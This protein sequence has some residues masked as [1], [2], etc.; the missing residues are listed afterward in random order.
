[1][2]CF[3]R[4]I[5][6]QALA[7]LMLLLSATALQA[8]TFNI[9]T[10][11]AGKTIVITYEVDVN[12]NA[13]PTGTL[14]PAN[15]SNQ[16]NVSGSNF[17]TVQT[18]DPSNPAADPSPTLTPFAGLSVGNLVYNDLNRD[19]DYDAGTDAGINGVL[20]RIY[21]DVNS[22]NVLDAGDGVALG[23]ATSANVSGQDGTYSFEVCP[24]VYIIEVAASNF[25]SGGALFNGGSPYVS[26]P[27]GGATDPDANNTN[28]DDNGDPVA[29]FGVATAAFT[30]AAA[31]SN[32]D[33][34]FKTPTTVTINNVTLAEG[35]GGT[36]TAYNFTVTRNDASEAFNLTV[37]T[38]DGTA[39]SASDYTAISGGTVSFT[40]GGSLTATVPV[41]VNHDN[42]V[43]D[44]ETF[45]VNLSGA[46]AGV[47]I[48]DGTGD[49]TITN[50]DA[51]VVTLTGGIAQN[52]GNAAGTISYTFTA[53]L[54]NPVQSGFMVAYNTANGTATTA[55]NDYAVNTGSLT[56]TGTAGEAKTI[57]VLVNRDTK[58][59]L[60]E[61][62]TVALGAIT[63]A[64]PGVTTAGSPQ[65]GTITNDDAAVVSILSPAGQLESVTPQNLFVAL[66]NP[67]DVAVTVQF[68]TS[69]GTAVAPG[70][71]TAI[72][73]QTV[74]FPAGSTTSQIV[75][76]TII[77]DAIVEADEVFNFA[78]GTLAASDRNVSL[79]TSTGTSTILN[80]DAATV[81]LTG[82]ITQ[83]E[84]NSGTTNY[85]FTAT[86]NNPVQGGF[87][88]AY[89]S[90][91]GTAMTAN[92]DYVD[93]DGPALSFAGT[94]NETKII[95]VKVNG[96]LNIEA[97]ETFTVALGAI[98]GAPAGVTV[99]GTSQTG[100]ITND[101]QDWGDAPT[102]MQS[103]FA[104]SY[105]TVSANNGARHALAI[106]G[107]RLGATVDA[108]LD[109]QPD[110]TATGDGADED[111]VTLPASLI[112]NLSSNITVNVSAA[113]KLDAWVDWNRDGDWND[114]GEQIFTTQSLAAGDNALSFPVPNVPIGAAFARFRVSNAGGLAP[115]GA[116]TEG[117]VEDYQ[118]QILDRAISIDNV[119][120][121]EGNAGTTL[122]N[123]TVSL[124]T[125]AGPGG[126]TFDIAT[127]D[128]TATDANNDYEPKSLT[129]QTIPQSQ[130]TYNFSVT[131]NG[132]NVVEDNEQ[133]FVNLSNVVGAGVAD[134]QGEGTITNDDNATL[135]LTGGASQN[136][137]TSFTFTATLNNPVQGGFTA[138]Y[139]TNDGTATT[140]DNDYTD[141]DGSLSFA[142]TA[143]ETKTFT[144]NTTA[145]NKVELNETFTAALGTLTGA[146]AVQI[147]AITKPGSPQTGTILNDDAATVAI[148]ANVSQSEATTPQA[149]S[150]TLS[151][152]VDV[153]VTVQFSTSDGTAMTGDNDYTGIGSQTVTFNAG[154]TTAQIV[155][156][157]VTNDNKVEANEV[158]NVAIGSLSAGGRN[159]SL[160]AST[161]TGTITNDDAATVTL[162]G[163]GGSQAEGNSGT[164]NYVFTATLNNPVQGGLTLAYTTSDG[165][166]T[167]AD[168]DYVDNDG[169]ALVFA[170]TAGETKTITVLVNGDLNIEA[171]ETFVVAL[172]VLTNAPAGVT[173]AGTSQIGTITND[174]QDWGDAPTSAQSG[175]AGTYPTLAADNGARHALS[176]GG[177]RL[178]AT[179]DGDLDGQPNVTATG[180]GADEDGVTLPSALV[181]NTTANITVNASGAGRLQAWVD[182]NRNGNW[183]DAGEQIFTNQLLAAGNN[184]LSFA[185]PAGASLGTSFA[186]FRL[187]TASGTP[188]NGGAAD[189]EVEDY[190]INIVN[191]QFSIDDPTVAEGDAGTTNLA[192]TITRS[193]N[194]NACSVQY[195]ITGGTA[196]T[197]DNDYQVFAA[198]TAN[199]T[200]G[201][202][203]TQTFNVVVNGDTKV[204]MNETVDVTLSNPVNASILDG[205]GSGTITNDD[206][207]IITI[208]SPTVTEGDGG[209]VNAT[210]NISLSNPS[211]A[212]I[213]LN[214]ATQDGTATLANLDYINTTGSHT[215]TPGQTSKTVTVSVNGDCAIEADE[216]FLLTLSG[217]NANG[218]NIIFSGNAATLD[219][220]GT[221]TN[222]DALPV[223]TCG[224]NLSQNAATGL[225]SASVTLPLPTTSSLCGS[226]TLEFRY[227][228][229]NNANV[230]TGA[231]SSYIPG[232]SNTQTFAVG[233]YEIEWRVTD[234]SGGNTCNLYLDVMDNQPP[235]IVCPANFSRNTDAGV[236]TTIVSYSP[237]TFSDNCSG[238]FLTLVSPASTASGSTFPKG[239]TTVSWKVT[240]G[241][242]LMSNCQFIITVVDAQ[243]PVITCPAN[244][245]RSNDAGLC[246]A[247]VTFT[248]ATATDNCPG[249]TVMQMGGPVSGVS[250]PAGTTTNV[251]FKATDGSNGTTTCTFRVTVLDTQ[252][253]TIVC[254][255]SMS[256]SN[257]PGMCSATV[258]YATPT[259]S[260]N[261]T[262]ASGS[263][264]L[265]SGPASGASF[266]KGQTTVV[267]IATD[268]EGLTKTCSFR[269]TVNDTQAPTINCP[270]SQSVPTASGLCT[271]A[272]V[273]YATPTAMDN[274]TPAP[275]VVR[276]GGPVSGSVFSAG[277]TNIT[278]RAIDGAGRSS[279]CSFSVTVT[280]NQPPTINC[281]MNIVQN[282]PANAC[283][284]PV[285]YATPTASDNCGVNTLYLL[286]GLASGSN[287]PLGVTTNV[288]RATDANGG[289][290]TCIFTVTVNCGAMRSGK[291]GVLNAESVVL[292]AE[293][294][295]LDLSLAPN[296]ASSTVRISFS[297]I[298]QTGGELTVFDALG[299]VVWQQSLTEAQ[300]Q[301]T[302]ND[303]TA[304][305]A[306]LYFVALRTNGQIA[307]K[308][309]LLSF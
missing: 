193:T 87:T 302:I 110:A 155:N 27:I 306:G 284:T 105:P 305:T 218:R 57:T 262:L 29:G 128:N 65:T 100:T 266:P 5:E 125:P 20:L 202:P 253:P 307:T 23:T 149:F 140:A 54:N 6:N 297:D 48:T 55:D 61:T 52:E 228:P 122:F 263:P 34:G 300:N 43:E 81:T 211:D 154:T 129:G 172:G 278:W 76:V 236:C 239:P 169:P 114:A 244:I 25:L 146:S 214:Y 1:M 257:T 137:G 254:P 77:N 69:N 171:D 130:S 17:T 180:D 103:G 3:F 271:S 83:N 112:I 294:V 265:Q 115:I 199:F 204:E 161:R 74:T 78:I 50:D 32:V 71:Y 64:P 178:G 104:S 142:G 301:A 102:S 62:F 175:L 208:S 95:T 97:N 14:P 70:D 49:G 223:I 205:S 117:E 242:G 309:L 63:G 246:S 243:N 264:S 9:G 121:T 75:P 182:F 238:S 195:A 235:S 191:T 226:S 139:T 255:G 260:D 66:N 101:E 89:T 200:A 256:V 30:V 124:N 185:V 145:D 167:T 296:P 190:A 59:E 268:A 293:R 108:D 144:V 44:N 39:S 98:M 143:G 231:F 157:T 219:G 173:V 209:T 298:G 28:N 60:D 237:P 259:A 148:A 127:Q 134:A 212:N 109:G 90:S 224:G 189:G 79:D 215:F 227:R 289:S 138:P 22:N 51:A 186:R 201:G 283:N 267:W 187:A 2:K 230:P 277:T 92:N 225:C 176:L 8:Q 13:C 308:Q 174:E 133:F 192:F 15:L 16:S 41:L 207:G 282:N 290:N 279:T 21:V 113:S 206:Q 58:V 196:T 273:N 85:V 269:I 303:L 38:A 304:W 261:C 247:V 221:I 35:T 285:V 241:A 164:S 213:V 160:G 153:S 234:G 94:A 37:N 131:V 152:P 188:V 288:W 4:K 232:A 80:D 68:N 116:T 10:L 166:T 93:N 295:A 286:T 86:L 12:A 18:D 118:I 147:A 33:F 275:T 274:C 151:N 216:T 181:I 45:T 91:D 258:V 31:N 132:D 111:G 248:N 150:V 119:T 24:G 249:V 210:F 233:R 53:T 240:D 96:D 194:A 250:F 280:D 26:S 299:R 82:G 158:F 159:V 162:T 120:I 203:L 217:L 56:F 11:P 251:T 198:G 72:V 183:N 123:F 184:A 19:G 107:L 88:V 272:A 163:G 245:I 197:A 252:T 84:G 222:D 7:A 99:G 42:V 170:G 36:T 220:T 73:N 126:V 106:G 165:T 291:L 156:V 141:N 292:K 46:P 47:I 270:G 177:L 276:I 287:F 179:L 136:E 67:V 135:T 281:P 168:A 40:A 229:V